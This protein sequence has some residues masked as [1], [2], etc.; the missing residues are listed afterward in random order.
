MRHVRRG[1]GSADTTRDRKDRA[2][3]GHLAWGKKV[4][5]Q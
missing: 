5:A 4:I 3:S 2:R 1:G